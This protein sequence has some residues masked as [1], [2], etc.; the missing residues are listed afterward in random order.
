[1][2]PAPPARQRSTRGP[3]A[4]GPAAGTQRAG[5]PNPPAPQHEQPL[6]DKCA[7]YT[8]PVDPVV[9]SK[10]SV[11]VD[12]VGIVAAT[13]TV[14]GV[15][16]G[17]KQL[18]LALTQLSNATSATQAAQAA[19]ERAE[20]HFVQSQLLFMVPEF[21]RIEEALDRASREEL[22]ADA[23][24][25]LVLWRQQ[26]GL[27]RGLLRRMPEHPPTLAQRL[28]DS[29]TLAAAAKSGL[30]NRK[31]RVTNTVRQ[32]SLAISE[33]CGMLGDLAADIVVSTP[34]ATS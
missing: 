13:A 8:P 19:V 1:V 24:R 27:M 31:R 32:A 9:A 22:H 30:N 7:L 25:A 21:V 4:P 23:Q 12:W 11:A 17:V 26:A 18:R 5:P 2:G 15:W 34:D 6:S 29:I 20:R 16:I 10:W 28:Q 3:P 14:S 33:V